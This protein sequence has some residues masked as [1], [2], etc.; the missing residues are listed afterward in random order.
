MRLPGRREINVG[1]EVGSLLFHNS[2]VVAHTMYFLGMGRDRSDGVLSLDRQG[3]MLL[4]WD[5]T[6][7]RW[8]AWD[9]HQSRL[10]PDSRMNSSR[11][12]FRTRMVATAR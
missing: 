10:L 9:A 8:R 4:R 2:D 7:S 5:T 3:R 11:W 6:A 12:A 1:D